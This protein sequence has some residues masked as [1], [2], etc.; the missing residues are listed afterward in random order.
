MPRKNSRSSTLSSASAKKRFRIGYVSPGIFGSTGNTLWNG[1]ADAARQY[2]VDLLCL[3]G[4]RLCDPVDFEGQGNL[5]YD[6]PLQEEVDGIIIWALSLYELMPPSAVRDFHHRYS[7]VPMVSISMSLDQH[8]VIGLD[9]VQG[10]HDLMAH[11]LDD[12]RY[13]KIA[14]LRGPATHPYAQERYQV[15][16]EALQAHNIPI[17]LRLISDPGDW[18]DTT[19]RRAAQLL[20]DERKLRPGVDVEALV[21]VNDSFALLCAQMLKERGVRIPDDVAIVGVNNSPTGQCFTPPLTSVDVPLYAQGFSTLEILL[22]HIQGK[23]PQ[24]YDLPTRLVLRESCGCQN[25]LVA[26]AAGYPAAVIPNTMAGQCEALRQALFKAGGNNTTLTT[27]QAEELINSLASDVSGTCQKTFLALLSR[28]LEEAGAANQPITIWQSVLSVMRN[29]FLQTLPDDK[30]EQL[31]NIIN[32]ARVLVGEVAHR[33]DAYRQVLA[34]Q[35]ADL[36]RGLS[37]KLITKFDPSE[38][39]DVLATHLPYLGI[40]SFYLI[41]YEAPQRYQFPEP[42]PEWSRLMLAYTPVGRI[43]LETE[44]QRFPTKQIIPGAIWSEKRQT[45]LLLPLYFQEQPLGYLLLG[46]GSQDSFL[47]NA[48][49]IEISS[50]LQGAFL[51]R[52]VREH[53]VEADRARQEAEVEK[54]RTEAANAELKSLSYTIGHDLRSP[55]RAVVAYSHILL[56]ELSG[57]LDA[58]QIDKLRQVNEVSLRMGSMVD[59]FLYFLRLGSVVLYKRNVNVGWMVEYLLVQL[60]KDISGRKVEFSVRPLPDC[61]ADERLLKDIFTNLI[62]N[63]IKFTVSRSPAK[64][65]IGAIERKGQ[66]CYFVRDNGVGFDMRYAGKLFGIFQRLHRL[67]EFEGIGVGLAIAHRIVQRHG[68]RIWAEAEVDKGATFFFTLE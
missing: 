22:Q 51:V 6:L 9:N 36:L 61:Y 20:F 42:I 16:C 13:R 58:S 59:E 56:T 33:A 63:A 31:E 48:L 21:A 67:D 10:I 55:I 57:K 28:F 37:Q 11:L 66:V 26:Q 19:A 50:A 8:P 60:K 52:Q 14:F 1:I 4:G 32:Q 44:G 18:T 64:I 34:Q 23:A 27:A 30:S 53:S 49:R 15:Y 5:L 25:P 39:M 68:G 43:S 24:R 35:Q 47:Y 7:S 17:D 62:S 41:I 46:I 2:D 12:H 45:M 3:G 29:L 38:L 54:E 40:P 65:E